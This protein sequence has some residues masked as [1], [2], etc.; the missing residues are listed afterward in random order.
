MRFSLH[1]FYPCSVGTCVGGVC[2]CVFFFRIAGKMH[3]EK[4]CLTNKILLFPWGEGR[5]KQ[6]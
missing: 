2:V 5:E 4:C 6:G 3:D 1:G